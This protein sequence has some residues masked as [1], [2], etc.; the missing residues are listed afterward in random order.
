MKG[1]RLEADPREGAVAAHLRAKAAIEEATGAVET[2]SMNVGMVSA[3][4]GELGTTLGDLG[5]RAGL[6]VVSAREA[7]D[8]VHETVRRVG[9][10]RGMAEHIG[11]LVRSIDAIA[12]HTNMLALN[13]TIEA[14]RAGEAGRGF[15]VVAKEIKSLAKATAA[16]TEEI[17]ERLGA[18]GAATARVDASM[19]SAS[20]GVEGLTE[21]VVL[22]ARSLEAQQGVSATVR[23]LIAEAAVSVDEISGQL[24]ASAALVDEVVVSSEGRIEPPMRLPEQ[25]RGGCEPCP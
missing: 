4:V 9:E 3:M 21:T 24:G 20:R 11:Q 14:A 15:A 22:L 18:I 10:L 17:S 19:S 12:S 16:A 8:E 6:S 5:G 25:A 7:L 23:A 13:A 1:L 2:V